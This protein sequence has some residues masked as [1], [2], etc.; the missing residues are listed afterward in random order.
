[1]ESAN[2][3]PARL[4]LPDPPPPL[5]GGVTQL[6]VNGW[7]TT[8]REVKT[9]RGD[10][11]VIDPAHVKTLYICCFYHDEIK[12]FHGGWKV[13]GKWNNFVI[14][15]LGGAPTDFRVTP[16]KQKERETK[17]RQVERKR[18]GQITVAIWGMSSPSAL[19]LFKP[20]TDFNPKEKKVNHMVVERN[21]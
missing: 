19:N 2:D 4:S 6:L 5:D 10:E 8:P 13:I 9:K 7:I 1:M 18:S 11:I 16:K 12:L 17:Y 14:L 20:L 15:L 3:G 21:L